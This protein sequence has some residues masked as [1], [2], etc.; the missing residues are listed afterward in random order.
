MPVLPHQ[1]DYSGY[2]NPETGDCKIFSREAISQ[3]T[4]DEYTNNESAIM[5]QLKSI[6]IPYESDLELASMRGGGLVY[7]RPYTRSDGT[8]V[9]GYWRSVPSA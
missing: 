1:V 5:A 8:E 6:G 9:R 3:M 4:G 2:L 7:V